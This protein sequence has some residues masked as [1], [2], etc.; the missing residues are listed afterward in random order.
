MIT[1]DQN[2]TLKASYAD[3]ATRYNNLVDE[4]NGKQDAVTEYLNK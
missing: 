2:E 1:I 4:I 3:L